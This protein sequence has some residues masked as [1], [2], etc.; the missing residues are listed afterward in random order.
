M[1]DELRAIVKTYHGDSETYLTKLVDRFGKTEKKN[2]FTRADPRARNRPQWSNL[3]F[4]F[5]SVFVCVQVKK[6]QV[7]KES[8]TVIAIDREWLEDELRRYLTRQAEIFNWITLKVYASVERGDL[9]VKALRF[10]GKRHLFAA[11]K[12]DVEFKYFGSSGR[13]DLS[14]AMGFYE[15]KHVFLVVERFRYRKDR[16]AYVP[17]APKSGTVSARAYFRIGLPKTNGPLH[18]IALEDWL[19]QVCGRLAQLYFPPK[20]G[21]FTELTNQIS[22]VKSYRWM[23]KEGWRIDIERWGIAKLLKGPKIRL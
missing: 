22:G 3:F 13:S 4:V 7:K 1:K 23:T 10:Q 5:P 6:E 16:V 2:I 12:K 18:W 11:V 20:G 14:E 21:N 9:D 8:V 17:N 15:R 19:T